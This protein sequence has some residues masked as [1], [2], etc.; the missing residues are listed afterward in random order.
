MGKESQPGYRFFRVNVTGNA[1]SYIRFSSITIKE[2]STGYPFAIEPGGMTSN[3]TPAPLVASASSTY[4][5]GYEP[6]KAFVISGSNASY[7]WIS[8]G[9]SPQWIQIDLGAGNEIAPTSLQ[10]CSDDVGGTGYYVTNFTFLGSNTGAFSGEEVPLYT[11]AT[12]GQGD[13][14][15]Y[16]CNLFTF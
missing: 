1:G 16:T 11:S 9:D 10:L 6:F 13:W 2:G 15:N 5:V 4:G 14:G 8:G 3:T 12:L 7:R